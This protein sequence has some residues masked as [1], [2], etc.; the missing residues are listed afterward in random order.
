MKYDIRP[1]KQLTDLLSKYLDFDSKQLKFGLWGGDLKIQDVNL[2]ND[3][4][5]PL[6]NTW[7]EAAGDAGLDIASFLSKEFLVDKDPSF[8]S[9]LDLKLEKGTIGYCRAKIPWTNLLLKAGDE[10]VLIDLR[11]VTIRLGLES[12]I[13]KLLAADGGPFSKLSGKHSGRVKF[14]KLQSNERRWKQEMIRIAE[15]CIAEGKD[16]PSPAE[17]SILK[18]EFIKEE[19]VDEQYNADEELK[20]S[21][22][23]RFV[24]PLA[25]SLGWRVGMG[26]K[27]TLQNFRITMIHDGVEAT[28]HTELVELF[29]HSPNDS[30][31]IGVSLD[32]SISPLKRWESTGTIATQDTTQEGNAIRKHVKVT[33]CGVF[34]REVPGGSNDVDNAETS[35]DEFIVQP[36][37]AN[38]F[39]CLRETGISVKVEDR[40]EETL[41]TQSTEES[42][43]IDM[44]PVNKKQRR[45]K[46]DK[47]R[48]LNDDDGSESCSTF[49]SE[50]ASIPISNY[51]MA[52]ENYGQSIGSNGPQD[53]LDGIDLEE[54]S[55]LFSTKI[56]LDN[57]TIVTTTRS[58]ELINRF[59]S[60][61][62]KIKGG[63][64]CGDL[65]KLLHGS[66][67]R[68]QL[69]RQ[70]LLYACYCVLKDVRRR[71]KLI[72]YF[73]KSGDGF[74]PSAQRPFRQ[75]YIECYAQNVLKRQAS[76][77]INDDT[78]GLHNEFLQRME[79]SLTVEQ[80]IL[81]RDLARRKGTSDNSTH[82]VQFDT[83]AIM[84]RG[85]RSGFSFDSDAR[86][87]IT[88]RPKHRSTHS[89]Y[90]M[91]GLSQSSLNAC[92]APK[93]QR[94][95]SLNIDTMNEALDHIPSARQLR[96]ALDLS[97]IAESKSFEG[98]GAKDNFEA[99]H[100]FDKVMMQQNRYGKTNREKR[101]PSTTSKNIG[102]VSS[103]AKLILSEIKFFHCQ[104]TNE[105]HVEDNNLN[106]EV[107][108]LTASTFGDA[109]KQN[110][111]DDQ[112][113]TL[114][115]GLII[116]GS[117][118]KIVYSATLLEARISSHK[119]FGEESK[120]TN[121]SADGVY[122]RFL[123]D[124]VLLA[125]NVQRPSI[126][127]TLS[128]LGLIEED[129]QSIGDLCDLQI[130][131]KIRDKVP[132][133]HCELSHKFQKDS[134]PPKELRMS[135]A[136]IHLFTDTHSIKEV[137][138][139]IMHSKAKTHNFAKMCESDHVRSRV[140]KYLARNNIQGGNFD[141]QADFEG[142]EFTFLVKSD[143][144][145]DLYLDDTAEENNLIIA[146]VGNIMLRHGILFDE[147]TDE[148]LNA[149][150]I[151]PDSSA[152]FKTVSELFSNQRQRFP[153]SIL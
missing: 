89:L 40:D 45:G 131:Q 26:L 136:M 88:P 56:R 73:Y 64:P 66:I 121:F 93:H 106:D 105:K 128:V 90:S 29:E 13:A 98:N 19:K 4:F 20:A 50:S 123:E 151:P 28:L 117:P 141:L 108:I 97:A 113:N 146:R 30:E 149:N 124:D 38:I 116:F 65:S 9:T 31:S 140:S 85:H 83:K 11:D 36:T 12:C 63:R 79:D 35:L 52:K 86:P 148:K 2:K 18:N 59:W 107:S 118:H 127:D 70:L 135:I 42:T 144:K 133:I 77:N 3:A 53:S 147:V 78:E 115:R 8:A 5:T 122:C 94:N 120:V 68:K 84:A 138:D 152:N 17:F 48:K 82:K 150:S 142:F 25:S 60:R 103:S 109:T 46:R 24:K 126:Q 34:L 23:E 92:K 74:I 81:Y 71:R 75:K 54:S 110:S 104:E 134:L 27:V 130:C 91:R 99:M 112:I 51:G 37:T 1:S 6:L 100:Q 114:N 55:A 44:T 49:Q 111:C 14:G 132:F 21:I 153:V 61:M 41:Q 58:L 80:I 10:T 15:Q 145:T 47:K 96:Y 139:C 32:A 72:E 22:L 39:L 125:G 57:I 119:N 95:Q 33:N 16:I 101:E 43:I 143:I 87:D 67:E 137:V 69:S 62:V 129:L 102:T 76:L 7:K